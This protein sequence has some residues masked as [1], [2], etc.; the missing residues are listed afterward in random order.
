VLIQLIEARAAEA[1]AG[2]HDYVNTHAL[3]AGFL[4]AQ[5][6]LTRLQEDLTRLRG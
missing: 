5:A 3:C 6:A 2:A 1:L 4:G